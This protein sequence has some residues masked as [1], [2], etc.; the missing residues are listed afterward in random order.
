MQG[1]SN[2]S[3]SALDQA[4]RAAPTARR[5]Q[6]CAERAA[7]AIFVN[8]TIFPDRPKESCKELHPAAVAKGQENQPPLQ[9][10]AEPIPQFSK[11]S[12]E[13]YAFPPQ[14]SHS[15]AQ[16]SGQA[17]C[18]APQTIQECWVL[19]I[20]AG[21]AGITSAAAS[22]GLRRSVGVDNVRMPRRKGKIIQLDLLLL[23]HQGLLW[24]W[25]G[26][27]GLAAVWLAPPCGTS[28]RAKEIP[29]PWE[30]KPHPLRSVEYPEG[31][32][33]LGPSDAERVAKANELYRLTARI[34]DFCCENGIVVI[35][36]NPYR[37]FFWHCSAIEHILRSEQAIV[38]QC[39]FCM[40]GGSRLKRTALLCNND[41]ITGLA[42]TCD[43]SHEHP[44]DVH[45][46]VLATKLESAYPHQFCK[47]FVSL[48]LQHLTQ[49]GCRDGLNLLEGDPANSSGARVVTTQAK[50]KKAASFQVI[51]EF[52]RRTRWTVPGQVRSTLQTTQWLGPAKIPG[53]KAPGA[54]ALRV[55]P[56]LSS[57]TDVLVE[58][59]WNPQE[60]VAKARLAGHPRHLCLGVP[61]ALRKAILACSKQP[62]AKVIETRAAQSRRWLQRAQELQLAENDFKAKLP[63]LF[64]E[65]LEAS[66]YADKAVADDL[67]QG[68]DLVGHLDL[69]AGWST[70]FRP[71]FLSLKD[72]SQ[73]T[74]ET[75]HQVIKEVEDSSQFLEELW[76]KS[77]DEVSKGW[78]EGPFREQDL[79]QGAVISK[80]FAIQQG[81]KVRPIDDLSQSHINEAFG[82]MG[83]IELHDVET[84][85]A[86]AILFLRHAG[87]GLLGKTIDLK[88]AYR[89]LPLSEEALNM[90]YVAVKDPSSGEVRFFR[91]LCLPFGAVAAVHA[92][93]RVSLAICH[94][95]NTFWHLPWS[96]FFDDFTLLSTRQLAPSAEASACFLLDLLGFEFYVRRRNQA[97]LCAALQG[98]RHYIAEASPRTVRAQTS[99]TV[100]AFT[101]ASQ[102]GLQ[103]LEMGL[104]AVLFNQE[105]Q[106]LCWFGIVLPHDLAEKL[107][108]GKS[109]VINELESIA[110]LLLFILAREFLRGKHVMCYLDNEAARITLLKLTSDS[111]A[112]TLLSNACALLEQELEMIPF[113]AR[114]P[115]KSNVADAPSRLD[116]TG[117]P[118]NCRFQDQVLLAEMA[119][120]VNSLVGRCA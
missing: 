102:E 43:G 15:G 53:F 82:S 56:L 105:G 35:I 117:L 64:K 116:F 81:S 107:M 1:T 83:K 110:V 67:A 47:H 77:L 69:P 87:Q 98:L 20:F 55:T 11:P 99:E 95:G 46:E 112:L 72:L 78:S 84:I 106:I 62:A 96:S 65:M 42:V 75:N 4:S 5:A 25:L 93:I 51:T 94:I 54:P 31:L 14:A 21:S 91:L 59:P 8:K 70:D 119:K 61:P 60:F 34:W 37:S 100:Y 71:A 39:D 44:W 88:S 24:K 16:R 63:E 3:A 27:P 36:E 89:Q 113:Y 45:E 73:L 97:S 92:F 28:S 7:T 33:G 6:A 103:G 66:H 19:E 76:Q 90:A 85:A 9:R 48:L 111:E 2:D 29:L 23:S 32:P 12:S 114:V 86:S 118:H 108:Q 57:A 50:T 79:P 38:V 120:L 41:L 68:F 52:C 115:S 58:V 10:A 74:Q 104:G 13:A 17:Q 30:D 109:K 49:K 18:T 80:R 22:A 101:D 26:S 40:M